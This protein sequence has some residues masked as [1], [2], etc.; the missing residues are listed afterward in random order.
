LAAYLPSA[1]RAELGGWNRDPDHL[2]ATPG[3]KW[4]LVGATLLAALID[5]L[6]YQYAHYSAQLF[7]LA[8]GGLSGFFIAW[9]GIGVGMWLHSR[10][11]RPRGA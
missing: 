10:R 1:S 9:C 4:L 2:G 3:A 7:Y 5:W 6:P 11:A 8:V